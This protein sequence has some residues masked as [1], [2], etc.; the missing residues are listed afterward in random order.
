MTMDR[1]LQWALLVTAGIVFGFVSSSYQRTNADPPA[2]V[3]VGS[4]AP[5]AEAL[6]QLKEINAQ[7]K[8]INTML[9][10]GSAK[11]TLVINPNA[12]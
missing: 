11:V 10:N 7:L 12:R 4:D 6:V 3:V 1:R 8:E 2:P 9:H 5:G